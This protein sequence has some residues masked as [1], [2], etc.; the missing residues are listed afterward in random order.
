MFD[1]LIADDQIELVVGERIGH[2]VEIVDHVGVG[3][4]VAVEAHS[5]GRLVLAAAD[6]EN[7]HG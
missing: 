2:A 4:R 3:A 1:H 5:A 7:L 6:V